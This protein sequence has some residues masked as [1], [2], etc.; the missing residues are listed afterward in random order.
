MV[1]KNMSPK[2][3][4]ALKKWWR[5]PKPEAV[6]NKGEKEDSI[7]DETT[8]AVVFLVSGIAGLTLAMS[9]CFVMSL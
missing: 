1:N 7:G 6:L 2:W 9:R 3:K 8:L 4:G 5:T